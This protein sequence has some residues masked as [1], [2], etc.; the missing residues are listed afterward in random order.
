VLIAYPLPEGGCAADPSVR[1]QLVLV[2]LAGVET[3]GANEKLSSSV[4]ELLE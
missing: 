2:Q 3:D 1:D 4:G